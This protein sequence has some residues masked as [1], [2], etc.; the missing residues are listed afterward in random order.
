MTKHMP[1]VPPASQPRHGPKDVNV[2]IDD[3]KGR[4]E[5]PGNQAEKGDE[6]NLHQNTRNQGYQQDR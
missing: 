5:H 1:P 2:P 4:Q 3:R 6:A